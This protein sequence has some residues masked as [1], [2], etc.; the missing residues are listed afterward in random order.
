MS[1]ILPA[2]NGEHTTTKL[3]DD[4]TT[5]NYLSAGLDL[6]STPRP[7]DRP[8]ESSSSTRVLSPAAVA[9][10]VKIE[11]DENKDSGLPLNQDSGCATRISPAAKAEFV[12]KWCKDQREFTKSK[13]QVDYRKPKNGKLSTHDKLIKR[14]T[15]P[16]TKSDKK[17]LDEVIGQITNNPT[18]ATLTDVQHSDFVQGRLVLALCHLSELN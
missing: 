4:Y 2:C 18:R 9:A 17:Q 13:Y 8:P 3:A 11:V 12:A 15:H 6:R 10:P 5:T 14:I 7:Q 1:H 16:F